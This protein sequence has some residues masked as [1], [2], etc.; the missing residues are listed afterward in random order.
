MFVLTRSRDAPAAPAALGAAG[1]TGLR[2]VKGTQL[3]AK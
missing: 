1:A 3:A 2:E